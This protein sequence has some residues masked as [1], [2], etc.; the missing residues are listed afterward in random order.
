MSLFSRPLSVHP[1]FLIPCRAHNSRDGV[2][3]VQGPCL[4]EFH[5]L[6]FNVAEAPCPILQ[7]SVSFQRVLVTFQVI[8]VLASHAP[9]INNSATAGHSEFDI[10][11]VART[12]I[13]PLTSPQSHSCKKC[14]LT[15][16]HATGWAFLRQGFFLVRNGRRIGR[17]DHFNGAFKGHGPQALQNDAL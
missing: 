5:G 7:L 6:A 11:R 3:T 12:D 17:D 8:S 14:P 4:Y 16:G 9:T 10:G 13:Q 15:Y 1:I 2:H